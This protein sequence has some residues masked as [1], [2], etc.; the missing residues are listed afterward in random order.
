MYFRGVLGG[1]DVVCKIASVTDHD[2]DILEPRI[3]LEERE[4]RK[5]GKLAFQGQMCTCGIYELRK[6]FL[7][8]V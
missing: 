8:F 7:L 6:C 3:E 1:K 5:R 4:R 2:K